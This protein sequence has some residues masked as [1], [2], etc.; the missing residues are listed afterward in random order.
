MGELRA[1]LGEVMSRRRF[2]RSAGM[3]HLLA[4]AVA[5]RHTE[6]FEACCNVPEQAFNGRTCV[7]RA[8]T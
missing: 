4:P 8:V 5:R 7:T 2:D 3:A 6:L 1:F